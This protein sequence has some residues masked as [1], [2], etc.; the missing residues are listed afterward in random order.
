MPDQG[1]TIYWDDFRVV[2]AI[3]QV[4]ERLET[5]RRLFSDV[6]FR[7]RFDLLSLRNGALALQ[8]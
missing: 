6:K 3:V 8:S 7:S 5:E 2:L 1:S 4:C